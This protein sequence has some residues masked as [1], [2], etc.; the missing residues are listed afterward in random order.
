[1]EKWDG[2]FVSN[3]NFLFQLANIGHIMKD[4]SALE[5]PLLKD[6][7]TRTLHFSDPMQNILASRILQ[8]RT[9]QI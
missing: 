7:F 1:M 8:V 3:V 2:M 9:K 4:K 5:L 6:E